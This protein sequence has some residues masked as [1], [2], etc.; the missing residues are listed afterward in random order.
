MT[1]QEVR[2]IGCCCV[3]VA[4]LASIGTHVVIHWAWGW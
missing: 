4:A 3:V 2:I 1:N